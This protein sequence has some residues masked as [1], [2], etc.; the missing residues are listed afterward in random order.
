MILINRSTLPGYI[1]LDHL[2]KS[3]IY[4]TKQNKQ[5]IKSI[6]TFYSPFFPPLDLLTWLSF[7]SHSKFLLVFKYFIRKKNTKKTVIKYYAEKNVLIFFIQKKGGK[8]FE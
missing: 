3:T 6:N 4:T 2:M 8:A 5:T 7:F 1:T